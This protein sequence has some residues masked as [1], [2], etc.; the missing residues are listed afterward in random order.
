MSKKIIYLTCLTLLFSIISSSAFSFS[1]AN[2][3]SLETNNLDSN[4]KYEIEYL[5]NTDTYQKIKFTN[6][7]TGEIEYLGVDLSKENPEYL[8]TYN[9]K[10]TKQQTEVLIT[11]LEDSIV[12]ENLTTNETKT[13]KIFNLED[14][15]QPLGLPGGNGDY[16][17]EHTFKGSKSLVDN[18]V[19][20]ISLIAGIVASVFGGPVVGVV[21]TIATY[22]LSAGAQKFYY[23]HELYYYKGAPAK[24]ASFVKYY[25]NSNY[26]GFINEVYN[27]FIW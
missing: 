7:E 18:G 11:K 14:S 16:V 10:Q 23:V 5:E 25:E 15:I 21:T 22:L 27:N 19:A 4:E 9:D 1:I 20:T 17:L 2:A 26:T 12:I 6:K 13:E 3:S 24:P 8:A